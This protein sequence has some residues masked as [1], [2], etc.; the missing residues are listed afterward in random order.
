MAG[1]RTLD[2]DR[3]SY[4]M[5]MDEWEDILSFVD[6]P[7][8]TSISTQERSSNSQQ[9]PQD[10]PSSH[11]V[12][13]TDTV[14][15]QE[16]TPEATHRP[17]SDSSSVDILMEDLQSFSLDSSSPSQQDTEDVYAHKSAHLVHSSL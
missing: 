4:D 6:D 8:L 14:T 16:A 5:M 9:L 15:R 7:G 1:V 10:L 12:S 3:G 11:K 17:A 2:D 13:V